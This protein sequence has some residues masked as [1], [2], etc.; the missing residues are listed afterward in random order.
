LANPHHRTTHLHH[1]KKKPRRRAEKRARREKGG[2]E[3]KVKEERPSK[4]RRRKREHPRG[5]GGGNNSAGVEGSR[6]VRPRRSTGEAVI[7][8]QSEAGE[9]R[10]RRGEHGVLIPWNSGEL[11]G[12]GAGSCFGAPL[13]GAAVLGFCLRPVSVHSCPNSAC[14]GPIRCAVLR[15]R[16]EFAS[17]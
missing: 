2:R 8:G 14:F 4:A 15:Q 1:Q 6:R 7:R 17:L 3:I 12:F 13:W 10:H 5:R 16:G 11:C 9:R